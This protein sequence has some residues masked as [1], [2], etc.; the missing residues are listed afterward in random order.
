MDK[1][2]LLHFFM[3]LINLMYKHPGPKGFGNPVS[4]L[5]EQMCLR[6]KPFID[7]IMGDYTGNSHEFRL[8]NAGLKLYWEVRR[9]D[10]R[11]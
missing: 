11:L 10:L 9:T 7:R 2:K 8:N 5:V 4:N 1:Y 6:Q 3:D